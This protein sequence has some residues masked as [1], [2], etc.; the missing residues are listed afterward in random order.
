MSGFFQDDRLTGRN[1]Q[2]EFLFTILL[3]ACTTPLVGV[4][5]E[6]RSIRCLFISYQAGR[7]TYF[8]LNY[9][10]L[11]YMSTEEYEKEYQNMLFVTRL[12]LK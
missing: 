10:Q 5:Y 3:K 2:G 6:K 9:S 8:G 12:F 11:A 7:I 4:E 1:R